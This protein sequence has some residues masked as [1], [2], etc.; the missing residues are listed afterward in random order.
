MK[1]TT[2]PE[3]QCAHPPEVTNVYDAPIIQH[4]GSKYIRKIFPVDRKGSP[5]LIDV[6]CVIEAFGVQ[7][8]ALQH[9]LKKVL[10]AG[11]RGKGSKAN[12]IRE[13]IDALR[14]ALDLDFQ[15]DSDTSEKEK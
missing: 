9:T 6:Y 8:P 14:R 3:P 12:D 7:C 5:I 10:A 4:S 11:R 13:A 15:R 1:K 2:S